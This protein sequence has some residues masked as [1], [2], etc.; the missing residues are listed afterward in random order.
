MSTCKASD[1]TLP[2]QLPEVGPTVNMDSSMNLPRI[3]GSRFCRLLCSALFAAWFATGALAQSIGAGAGASVANQYPPG[4]ITTVEIAE[5]ALADVTRDRA[6]VEARF[7]ADERACY[8]RFFVS[9]CLEDAR[10][11]RRSALERLRSIENEANLYERKE[12]V[13]ERDKA[14]AEKRVNDEAVDEQRQRNAEVRPAKVQ[15]V[16]PPKA[17]DVDEVDR[18]ARH[19]QKLK[20]L[21]AEEAANAQKRAENIAAYQKKVEEAQAHQKEV[22]RKKAEKERT[23][24]D[25]QNNAPA[26][27]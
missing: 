17:P 12:R 26:A 3:L 4:S 1:V 10:E 16:V 25:R 7:A 14:L 5:G 6:A 9:S 13:R 8:S 19:E 23:R 2:V 24:P 21:Q 20:Q 22:E 27:Q 15:P 11:Q 18:V